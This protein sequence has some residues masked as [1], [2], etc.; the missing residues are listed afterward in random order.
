VYKGAADAAV[1]PLA[2]AT[3][4]GLRLLHPLLLGDLPKQALLGIHELFNT[5]RAAASFAYQYSTSSRRRWQAACKP[6]V[7]PSSRI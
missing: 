3:A 7:S 1:V 4:H 6:L 5:T 2:R